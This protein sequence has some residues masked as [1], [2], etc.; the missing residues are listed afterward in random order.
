MLTFDSKAPSGGTCLGQ[1]LGSFCDVGC[2]FV[3]DL[4]FILDLYFV[5]LLHLSM[6]FIHIC[7]STSSFTLTW[8]IAGFLHPFY[9]FSPAHRRVIRNTFIFNHSVMFS[10][11]ALRFLMGIFYP[12]S[13]FTLCSFLTFLAQPAIIKASL[14]AGSY[15]LK[16]SGLHTDPRITDP[17]HLFF[18]FTVIHNPLYILN[19]YFYMS[20][21][22]NFYLWWKLWL[23]IYFFASVSDKIRLSSR[24]ATTLMSQQPW[25]HKVVATLICNHKL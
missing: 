5:V 7:F 9:T 21:L 18:W 13:F 23:K 17:A 11:Q 14:G 4:H 15:S 2:H 24:S 12:Q 6:F 16:F 8:T 19:L 22:Q 10:P 3:F 20:I 25:K 1:L